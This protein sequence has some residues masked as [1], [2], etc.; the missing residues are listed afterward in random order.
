[1]ILN[2]IVFDI[3]RA[4]G[5]NWYFYLRCRMFVTTSFV[6]HTASYVT[7]KTSYTVSYTVSYGQYRIRYPRSRALP[8]R[9]LQEGGILHHNKDVFLCILRH[10]VREGHLQQ[11]QADLAGDDG[12]EEEPNSKTED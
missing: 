9:L 3:V 5:K 6:K 2:D 10:H 11:L 1:M 8:H 7:R 4:I 12:I